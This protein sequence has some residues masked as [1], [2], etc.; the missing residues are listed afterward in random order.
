MMWDDYTYVGLSFGVRGG[1]LFEKRWYQHYLRP[2]RSKCI[3]F[4]IGPFEDALSSPR[5]MEGHFFVIRSV[6]RGHHSSRRA[7][8]ETVDG[9]PV[10]TATAGTAEA[11]APAVAA[12]AEPCIKEKAQRAAPRGCRRT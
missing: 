1:K 7:M 12:E 2:G 9:A 5:R 11:E 8:A 4:V 6:R 3:I 10:A